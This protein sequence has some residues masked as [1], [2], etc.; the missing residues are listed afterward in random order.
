MEDVWNRYG[1]GMEYVWNRV[2]NRYG[3]DMEYVWNRQG[4]CMES[5]SNR[6][7]MGMEYVWNMYGTGRGTLPPI[8]A[9]LVGRP[10]MAL[11]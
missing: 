8:S 10:E 9:S 4:I 7:G 3:I 1:I 2:W 6:Y 5:V 11:R